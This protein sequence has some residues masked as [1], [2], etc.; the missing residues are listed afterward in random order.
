MI[1]LN[2]AVMPLSLFTDGTFSLTCE[3]NVNAVLEWHFESNAE[4]TALIFLAKHLRQHG[5]KDMSLVMPYIPNARKDR[6]S[7]A[8]EVFTMKYFAEVINWLQFDEVV[9]LDPHSDVAP[10]LLDRVRV[11]R[12]T[13]YIQNTIQDINSNNL[14]AFFPDEGACKRY[15]S[16]AKLPFVFAMKRRDK[17]TREIIDLRIETDGIDVKGKDVLMIDDICSSGKTLLYSAKKLKALGVNNIY[18][19]VSHCEPGLETRTI[20]LSNEVQHIYTTDSILD[21]DRKH[22][23]HNKVTIYPFKQ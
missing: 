23:S 15:S 20:L 17:K 7:E 8:D 9:V 12:P 18:L 13:E 1:K 22:L 16:Q 6:V 21:W 14:I 4:L 10:A 2:G 19:Y 5:C 3:P 11:I